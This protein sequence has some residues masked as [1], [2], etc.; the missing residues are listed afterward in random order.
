MT[1]DEA[2]LMANVNARAQRLFEDGYRARW[3][4]SYRLAIR[5]SR[6]AVY[7][8][9]TQAQTCDCPFFCKSNH[10]CKHVLGYC[11]RLRRQRGCRLFIAATLLR[12]WN[13]L[14]DA[15]RRGNGI[16]GNDSSNDIPC[17]QER[18]CRGD[19]AS[20][21]Q[22]LGQTLATPSERASPNG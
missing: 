15:P 12:M 6:G 22:A 9:D 17:K 10:P 2:R 13:S 7:E 1:L 8:V 3:K 16:I 20:S 19:A 5:N 18:P 11:R 4:R 14:D 21:T